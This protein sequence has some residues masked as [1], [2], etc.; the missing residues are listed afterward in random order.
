MIDR[1]L[2]DLAAA[3]ESVESL[4]VSLASPRLRREGVPLPKVVIPDADHRLYRLLEAESPELAHSRYLAYL[5]QAESFADACS[6]ARATRG[7]DA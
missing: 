3:E 5:R 4:V 7:F 6:S 1:G 2:A